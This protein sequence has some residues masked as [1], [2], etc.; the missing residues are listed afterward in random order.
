MCQAEAHDCGLVVFVSCGHVVVIVVG[1][2]AYLNSAEGN[3]C[4]RVYVPESVG[5]YEGIN[6]I[7]E[8]FLRKGIDGAGQGQKQKGFS[9]SE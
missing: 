9:H 2:R 3:L 4:S 1:V 5:S 6:V 8:A 7:D